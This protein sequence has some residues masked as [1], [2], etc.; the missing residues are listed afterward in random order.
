MSPKGA[1][2]VPC[3]SISTSPIP[4]FR[5]FT[6]RLHINRHSVLCSFYTCPYMRFEVLY[7][8][9]SHKGSFVGPKS[10]SRTDSNTDLSLKR[11]TSLPILSSWNWYFPKDFT[12]SPAQRDQPLLPDL[13]AR[14][15]VC[16]DAYIFH[17]HP[18]VVMIDSHPRD[19]AAPYKSYIGP[20][21]HCIVRAWCLASVRSSS[22][23]FCSSITSLKYNLL[24]FLQKIML[25]TPFCSTSGPNRLESFPCQLIALGTD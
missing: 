18:R 10:D 25:F 21:I 4:W 19:Y 9:A 3:P 2:V 17:I 24:V 13:S 5:V 23:I 1:V 8:S 16:I 11:S 15:E 6:R 20:V 22:F 14:S 7:F 12:D